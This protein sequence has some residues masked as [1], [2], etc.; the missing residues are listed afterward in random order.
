MS[1]PSILPS[2]DAASYIVTDVSNFNHLFEITFDVSNIN[3]LTADNVYYG[4]S[5]NN[6]V[7]DNIDFSKSNVIVGK[8]G[9]EPHN[10]YIDQSLKLDLHR[11]ILWEAG[12]NLV[13][14][15]V[16]RSNQFFSTMDTKNEDI[17]AQ[18]QTLFD[19]LVQQPP[20]LFTE[21]SGNSYEYY[22][23]IGKRLFEI[24]LQDQDRLNVLETDI[25]L[26][27]QN[28]P[29]SQQFTVN[30]KFSPGD[31]VVVYINYTI[32]YGNSFEQASTMSPDKS[33]RVYI[34]L[35]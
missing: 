21:I 35:S 27:Q 24:V 4:F 20:R 2:S 32:N 12:R 3:N 10:F 17:E 9:E 7:V 33:Y 23:Y 26:A 22:Y 16:P 11:H 15:T 6:S 5:Q 30:L 1:T 34:V 28:N 13:M 19:Q 14:D 8:S 18:I 25:S 31:V 29:N